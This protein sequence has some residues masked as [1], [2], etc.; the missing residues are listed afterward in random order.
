MPSLLQKGGRPRL[1]ARHVALETLAGTDHATL[2]VNSSHWAIE[3]NNKKVPLST[4]FGTMSEKILRLARR[5]Q[6]I[7]QI[8]T[9]KFKS[10]EVLRL[11]K[12][13]ATMRLEFALAQAAAEKTLRILV[14][15][16]AKSRKIMQDASNDMLFERL[17]AGL[18][19][20]D[21]QADDLPKLKATSLTTLTKDLAGDNIVIV[22][23]VSKT[24]VVGF[25]LLEAARNGFPCRKLANQ[26]NRSGY[27][28]ECSP[29]FSQGNGGGP[30]QLVVISSSFLRTPS[31][32]SQP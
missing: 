16:D 29:H 14:T 3:A 20:L 5:N 24:E 19:A 17:I 13:T 26:L 23:T 7:L 1:H 8:S 31:G 10:E 11:R 32:R 6:Q 28:H 21:K 9:A 18:E 27:S 22:E 25:D 4:F 12:Q 15:P 30:C 2:V